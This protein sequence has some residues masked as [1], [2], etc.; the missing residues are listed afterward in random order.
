MSEFINIK[1][2]SDALNNLSS[3]GDKYIVIQ[4]YD[5]YTLIYRHS[6]YQPWIVAYGY[7]EREKCW[8][9]GHYFEKLE[10]AMSFIF[11]EEERLEKRV[12]ED[13]AVLCDKYSKPVLKEIIDN[14]NF[15]EGE[16]EDDYSNLCK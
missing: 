4:E 13:M 9:N 5:D 11:L 1:N 6:G 10:S 3:E 8:G 7:D 12:A 2:L 15:E 16:D 14:F